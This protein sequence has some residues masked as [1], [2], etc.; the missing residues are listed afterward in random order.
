MK[1]SYASQGLP[2]LSIILSHHKRSI[3]RTALVDSGS[4]INVLP[5]EDGLDLGLSWEEQ[6]VPLRDE[7]FLLGAPMFGVLLTVQFESYSP[8]KQAFAWTQK[9]QNEVR[10]ILGQTNFFEYFEIRFQGREK[11]FEILPYE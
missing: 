6:S 9:S 5:Y 4:T 10:L 1:F 8:V 7:G 3:S 11:T 2:F